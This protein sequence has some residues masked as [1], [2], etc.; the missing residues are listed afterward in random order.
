VSENK[1]ILKV[2]ADFYN[3]LF[4]KD[5]RGSC[6]LSSNFW[7]QGDSLTWEE[8]EELEAPFTEEEIKSVVFSCYLEGAPGPDGIPFF[9]YQ[10][11]WDVI[12]QDI[13]SM[14]K[15]FQDGSLDLFRLNFAMLTLIPKVDNA[16]AM[17]IFRPISFL[18]CS[19]KMFSKLLT[20]RLE[21][22]C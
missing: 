1:D 6:S 2:A 16:A 18:N 22:V 9:F 11:F 4:R 15:D 3:H 13:F 12:K 19:F 20:L 17:K 14:F 7:D 8:C 21:R 10:Q 5:E